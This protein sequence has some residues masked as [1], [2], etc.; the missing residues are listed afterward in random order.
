MAD[1]IS[2]MHNRNG[3]YSVKS[4]YYV[5]WQVLRNVNMAECSRGN[6]EQK[7]WK[8]LWKMKIPN[9]IKIFGW[10]ACH[11]ILPT[12]YNLV[13]QNIIADTG[14]PICLQS[15]GLKC[16][17]Y[18]TA[19]LPRMC[20]LEVGPSCRNFHSASKMCYSFLMF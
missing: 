7:V 8:A 1:S 13:K 14:C 4:G 5:A 10:R 18:G 15:P 16:T 9:K 17:W 11:E 12:R 20:G 6:D 2:W 19:L 3:R